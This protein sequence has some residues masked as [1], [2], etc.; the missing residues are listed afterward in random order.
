MVDFTSRLK[1]LAAKCQFRDD[2]EVVD[3]VL[4]QLIWG[5]RNAD[6]EKFVIGRE[7]SLTL[8]VAI[9][10]ARSH[11]AANKRMKTLAGS[12]KSH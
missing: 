7:K 5:T 6:A 9:E 11:Q 1:N 8:A 12:G 2:A 4:D 3:R 10:I